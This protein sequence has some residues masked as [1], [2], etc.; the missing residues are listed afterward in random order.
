[1]LFRKRP[2]SLSLS[3]KEKEEEKKDIQVRSEIQRHGRAVREDYALLYGATSLSMQTRMFLATTRLGLV[4]IIKSI[5]SSQLHLYEI[6]RDGRPCHFYLDV[7]REKD[8]S[9]WHPVVDITDIPSSSSSSSSL[10]NDSDND[11]DNN[12]NNNNNNNN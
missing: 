11:S 3:E 8:Y 10:N 1:L 7:E 12:N 9:A 2:L 5:E 6:I 4:E